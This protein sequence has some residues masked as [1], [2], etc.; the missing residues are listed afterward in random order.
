M[1]GSD[2]G[3]VGEGEHIAPFCSGYWPHLASCCLPLR[4]RCC[5]CLDV[6]CLHAS[7]RQGGPVYVS[8]CV[9]VCVCQW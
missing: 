2:D 7:L 6:V 5:I 8:V 4:A 1:G 3:G 9:S